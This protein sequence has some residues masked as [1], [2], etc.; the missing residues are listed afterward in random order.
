M[1]IQHSEKL[2]NSIGVVTHLHYDLAPYAKNFDDI[3][4]P[5]LQE[6]GIRHLREGAITWP[7]FER[8]WAVK[9]MVRLAQLGFKFNLIVSPKSPWGD[10][11]RL[12]ELRKLY[13]LLGGAVA[14]FES[15]NEPDIQSYLTDWVGTTRQLQQTLWETVKGDPALAHVPVLGP[16]LVKPGSA[17]KLGDVSAWCDYGNLHS[18][19]AASRPSG[20]LANDVKTKSPA[21]PGRP[22]IVTECGYHNAVGTTSG[23]RPQ[24][25]TAAGVYAPVLLLEH[26]AR[27][28]A[29]SYWYELIDEAQDDAKRDPEK[30]FGLLRHDGTLKP[31]AAAI[32]WLLELNADPGLPYQPAPY[33]VTVDRDDARVLVT[34][35]RDGSKLVHVWRDVSYGA[36]PAEVTVTLPEAVAGYTLHQP[37]ADSRPVEFGMTPAQTSW[38][39]VSRVALADGAPQL[40]GSSLRDTSTPEVQTV[41]RTL[42][43]TLS[44]G[45]VVVSAP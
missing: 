18:Y 39:V 4:L 13:D 26:L 42:S 44:A 27:G 23:H 20:P 5:R 7:G 30:N 11:T 1:Q 28:F 43:L 40:L 8:D 25:E 14:S 10:A 34:G 16:S 22:W 17:A 2:V 12:G 45:V 32:K 33:E 24:S 6:L 21:T 35:K 15:I 38:E 19:A 41:R 29:R 3:I 31:A 9:R 37:D 36:A